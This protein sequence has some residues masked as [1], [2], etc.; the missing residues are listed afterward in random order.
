MDKI[1]SAKDLA[2]LR[3]YK[4]QREFI[5]A[6]SRLLASERTIKKPWSGSVCESGIPAFINQGR[7]IARCPACGGIEY[8]DRT[9][10]IFFCLACGNDWR[11]G[12]ALQVIFPEDADDIE[13]ELLK[14]EIIGGAM[15]NDLQRALYS[16]PAINGLDRNWCA[17][18][19]AADL[20]LK[21]EELTSRREDITNDN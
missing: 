3:G 17:G 16:K 13:A 1:F 19:S 18:Q 15:G 14:R 12:E 10:K 6:R 11:G 9:E 5:L 2:E 20:Q 4:S 8:V 21:R 7:W